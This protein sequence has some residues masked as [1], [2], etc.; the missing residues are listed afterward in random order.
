M[1]ALYRDDIL[2]M[3]ARRFAR[4]PNIRNGKMMGHPGFKTD[5][6]GKFFAFI[7]DDGVALKMPPRKYEEIMAREDVVG[8]QPGKDSKPMSTWIVWTRAEADEYAEEWEIFEYARDYTASEPPNVKKKR[9][10]K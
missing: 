8:F 2:E 6:N 1:S 10:K 4:D 3:C 9:K 5:N 7:Y